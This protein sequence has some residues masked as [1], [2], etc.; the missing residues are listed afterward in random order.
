MQCARV[1]PWHRRDHEATSR[2]FFPVSGANF[3]SSGWFDGAD[4][5]RPELI[6]MTL[7]PSGFLALAF[8]LIAST[9]FAASLS[10][11]N[12]PA[13][14]RLEL[15]RLE[16]QALPDANRIVEGRE[17]FVAGT[18]SPIAVRAGIEVLKQGGTAADAATAVALTQ[19]STAL[20][21]V[22]SYAGIAQILYFE[23]KS[24][25]IHSID[26]GWA[27]YLGETDPDSIPDPSA[28][29]QAGRKTLVPGFMAGMETMQKR[30]GVLS[31]GDL[32][33]PA[34]WYAE[35]GV[36]ISR[37]L[38]NFFRFRAKALS[39]T[40]SGRQ[41]LH[42][43]GGKEPVLGKKFV[44]TEL[45]QTL[46]A[47]AQHG[48]QYMYGGTWGQSYVEAVRQEGGKVTLEDL[49]R[50]QPIEEEPLSTTFAGHIVFGP[51]RS[52]EGGY[53]ALAALNL[54]EEL[55]IDALPPYWADPESFRRL[56]RVLNL[57]DVFPE[58]MLARA[59]SKGVDL[60][61]EDRASKAFAVALAPLMED[62]FTAPAKTE[63]SAHTAGIV[64]VDRHGNVAAVVHSINTVLWGTTGIVVGGIPVADVAA[65]SQ[66][67]LSALKPGDRLRDS[68]TP[69]IALRNGTPALA[70]SV[71]G[72]AL[73]RETVRI[74]LGLLRYNVGL[75]K[76]MTAPP[77]LVR[78]GELKFEFLIP[79][80][81]YSPEFLK[82][83]QSAGST[84]EIVTQRESK[85][86]RGTGVFS[87][88][89]PVSGRWRSVEIVD[90]F[91]FCAG[92]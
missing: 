76:L 27:S 63:S 71:T 31:F 69:L 14:E 49:Q 2:R 44:Q 62:F 66:S 24:G 42:Q 25:Q 21:S 65:Q 55:K 11:A 32:F 68:M 81:S 82:Q 8:L 92:Y 91:S 15:E 60:A 88:I 89:E 43:G 61:L 22:V 67:A 64:V 50:Y 37:S 48:A 72:Y 23:A 19:V 73:R 74:V 16:Q 83:V 28:T 45:G 53:Q 77:L 58:W 39:R 26:A 70:V 17:G 12:W 38:A 87:L 30:F 33:E 51:G 78:N 90:L 20:G 1:H 9:T 84:F 47:V 75:P 46:R 13:E 57:T 6:A 36:T 54:I 40:K 35:N 59:R 52:S 7:A 3:H 41:F 86:L 79:E 80:R 5:R 56:S 34:I 10:P 18:L 85:N 29:R 4:H